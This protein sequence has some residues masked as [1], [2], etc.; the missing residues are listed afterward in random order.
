MIPY[1]FPLV[2]QHILLDCADR[3]D[4]RQQLS[5]L[6]GLPELFMKVGVSTFW[7]YLQ[8]PVRY[9]LT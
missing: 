4:V 8:A 3:I 7:D 5:R 9:T 2:V 1:Q 6:A